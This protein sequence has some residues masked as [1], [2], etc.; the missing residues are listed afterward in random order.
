MRRLMATI[1]QYQSRNDGSAAMQ[2]RARACVR[3]S[4]FHAFDRSV[5]R[6]ANVVFTGAMMYGN[7]YGGVYVGL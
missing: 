4:N 6:D 3:A 1:S 7:S 2:V 5:E